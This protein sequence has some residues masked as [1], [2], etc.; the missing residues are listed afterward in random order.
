MAPMRASRLASPLLVPALLTLTSCGYVH[1]GRVPAPAPVTTLNIVTDETLQ[2]ENTA[3]RQ[4]KKMLQQELALTRA[5]G[6]ALKMAI[7]NRAA[8]GDTSKQLIARLQESARELTTLRANYAQLKAERDQAIASAG[9]APALKAKLGETEEKLAASLRTHTELQQEV[10]RLRG[11]VARTRDENASLTV[12]VKKI[13]ADNQQAQA[14]LAQ[15]N[16][17]LLAQKEARQLA[18]LDAETFRSELKAVAPNSSIL[19]RQRSGAAS[20]ARSLVAEH[21]AESAA[22]KQQLDLLRS[23]VD[24]LESE[25]AKWRQAGPMAAAP[26]TGAA[27]KTEDVVATSVAAD[28][29][30]GPDRTVG[31]TTV[32]AEASRI[33]LGTASTPP[34]DASLSSNGSVA[35]GGSSVVATLATTRAG[36]NKSEPATA[37]SH[38]VAGG[39]TLAKI[40]TLYYGT[41]ARWGDI[42][43][44]NR[45][46]LGEDNKLVV[47]RTLRIP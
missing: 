47:G 45:D 11:D 44:A 20:E 17:D 36:V 5:Q 35:R 10:T 46:V 2:Q 1:I 29:R 12:E 9:E 40:S 28:A 15:L 22:L 34:P 31:A 27:T 33:D 18:E 13:T 30:S 4:E 21:A 6:E 3:L 16:T 8:D 23:K 25:R 38:V 42:L 39:D 41:P 43:T 24:V 7:Q 14:A 19:S 32:V 37:R 26:A